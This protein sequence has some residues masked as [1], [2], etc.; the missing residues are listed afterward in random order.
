MGKRS[1]EAKESLSR[2]ELP[3]QFVSS[4]RRR[5]LVSHKSILPTFPDMTT[6]I[7]SLPFV[8]S[9]PGH[10]VL[11][12]DLEYDAIGGTAIWIRSRYVIFDSKKFNVRLGRD[13]TGLYIDKGCD[14]EII[15]AGFSSR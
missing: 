4:V 6:V 11:G 5:K 12:K 10:F 9:S 1:P 13:T 15:R 7:T 8:I 3:E 14:P 2:L